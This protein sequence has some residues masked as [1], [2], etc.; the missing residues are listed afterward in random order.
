MGQNGS[1]PGKVQITAQPS[2]QQVFGSPNHSCPQWKTSPIQLFLA[3][4]VFRISFSHGKVLKLQQIIDSE[5]SRKH[6]THTLSHT[7]YRTPSLCGSDPHRSLPHQRLC[8]SR[9]RLESLAPTSAL[10]VPAQ[11]SG[12]RALPAG[13]PGAAFPRRCPRGLLGPYC[14]KPV[15]RNT[16]RESRKRSPHTSSPR[17]S[18]SGPRP[19]TA[20]LRLAQSNQCADYCT[21]ALS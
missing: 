17:N 5:V 6:I 7:L 15:K 13:L 18:R 4:G 9:Q 3:L 2:F 16:G 8:T 19:S 21:T 12:K 14:A 11:V 20:L 10:L 1:S